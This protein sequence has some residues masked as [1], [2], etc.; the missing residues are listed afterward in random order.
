M[1]GPLDLRK[2]LFLQFAILSV[3]V[4]LLGMAAFGL[5]LWDFQF[6][7]TFKAWYLF[8]GGMPLNLGLLI[9]FGLQHSI[10]ARKGFKQA[11]ARWMPAD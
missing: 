8:K 3:M 9:G 6:P 11:I 5:M 4:G 2:I 1:M 10:M 7:G